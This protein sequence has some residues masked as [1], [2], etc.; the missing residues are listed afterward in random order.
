LTVQIPRRPLPLLGSRRPVVL[1]VVEAFPRGRGGLEGDAEVE[2]RRASSYFL[3]VRQ[4][5]LRFLPAQRS[6]FD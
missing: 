6:N 1:G 4:S 2:I 3:I 5:F